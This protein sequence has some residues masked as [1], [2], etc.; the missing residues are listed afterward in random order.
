M[1]QDDLAWR[2]ILGTVRQRCLIISQQKKL[3]LNKKT[4][5]WTISTH[6]KFDHL[7]QQARPNFRTNLILPAHF[8]VNSMKKEIIA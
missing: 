2:V 6:I 3:I 1:I 4:R 8:S 5:P 7:I